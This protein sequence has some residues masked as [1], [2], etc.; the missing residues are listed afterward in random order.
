MPIKVRL[1][2]NKRKLFGSKAVKVTPER[3]TVAGLLDTLTRDHV[4]V[5]E[6]LLEEN[7]EISF[8]YTVLVNDCPVGR[9]SWDETPIEDGDEVAILSMISGG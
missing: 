1:L 3:W 7:G 4:E 6:E 8:R 2:H 9:G 5:G